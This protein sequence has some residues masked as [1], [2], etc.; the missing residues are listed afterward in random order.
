M[1]NEYQEKSHYGDQPDLPE[2]KPGVFVNDLQRSNEWWFELVICGG[3]INSEYGIDHRM[4]LYCVFCDHF[5]S[6]IKI[7]RSGWQIITKTGTDKE[8]KNDH[9]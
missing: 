5:G 9:G 4:F 3:K 2:N 1:I 7:P 8:E 6:R